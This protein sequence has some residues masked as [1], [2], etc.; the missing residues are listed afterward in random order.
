MEEFRGVKLMHVLP[1]ALMFF[2]VVRPVRDW[3]RQE[4]ARALAAG[5]RGVGPVGVLYVL[6]T[7]NFGI[8]VLEAEVQLREALENLLRVRPRTKELFLGHPALYLALRAQDPKRSW[9]LPP[10]RDWAALFSEHLYPHPH[11][12]VGEPAAHTVRMGVRLAL[13]WLVKRIYHWGKR[14]LRSD[15]RF[16]VLRVR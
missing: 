2:T 11:L 9:L 3:L 1:I 13:G 14:W 16:G 6:R 12:P 10:G 4:C 8:P 7:G 15:S 5:R